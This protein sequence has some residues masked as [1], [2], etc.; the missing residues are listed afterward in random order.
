MI[1][2]QARIDTSVNDKVLGKNV[3]IGLRFQ[4]KDGTFVTSDCFD[5]EVGEAFS[6]AFDELLRAIATEVQK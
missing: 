1:T 2:V 3:H 6:R 4:Y 5:Y